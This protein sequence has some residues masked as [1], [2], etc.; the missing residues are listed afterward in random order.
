MIEGRLERVEY[1]AD[2]TL[3]I[4]RVAGLEL[5]TAEDAWR[6]NQPFVS[7]I[8]EGTYV[9]V[10]RRFNRGQYDA[11]EVTRVPG[12]SLILIHRGNS[13]EH[14]QGCIVVGLRFGELAGLGASVLDSAEAFGRLYERLGGLT[15]TLTIEPAPGLPIRARNVA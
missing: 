4:L 12:R 14:V 5:C 7:C 10:P 13:D 1:L 9:V 8:P 2:V 15:W 11:W 6:D 3:G